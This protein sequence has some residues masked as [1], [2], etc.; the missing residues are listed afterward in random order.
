MTYKRPHSAPRKHTLNITNQ[1]SHNKT[2][3]QDRHHT[4][5]TKYLIKK[6]LAKKKCAGS[7]LHPEDGGRRFL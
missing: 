7:V 2:E 3:K 4:E 1:C 6:H 5:I